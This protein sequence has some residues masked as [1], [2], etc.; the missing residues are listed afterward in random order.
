[1]R[2]N[3]CV[4]STVRGEFAMRELGDVA[5]PVCGCHR[6]A[7]VC[8]QT[9]KQTNKQTPEAHRTTRSTYQ[10]PIPILF[11]LNRRVVHSRAV[12]LTQEMR[13]TLIARAPLQIAVLRGATSTPAS[14]TPVDRRGTHDIVGLVR[15]RRIARATFMSPT[16]SALLPE[17][18]SWLSMYQGPLRVNVRSPQPRR[19]RPSSP[20]P[21][22]P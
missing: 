2:K 8:Y 6:C 17:F 14:S 18:P 21:A 11:T 1:M 16:S 12:G 13:A 10:I 15:S 3:A 20:P 5:C 4:W 19:V 22:R 7:L 9:N